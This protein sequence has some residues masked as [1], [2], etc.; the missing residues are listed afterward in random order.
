MKAVRRG[1]VF[2]AIEELRSKLIINMLF[3][4]KNIL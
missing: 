1:Y 2:Y 4:M 3:T